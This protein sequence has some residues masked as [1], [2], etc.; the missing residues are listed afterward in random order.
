MVANL[1]LG[2]DTHHRAWSFLEIDGTGSGMIHDVCVRLAARI[3]RLA[4][5]CIAEGDGRI[6]GCMP[7]AMRMDAC[8]HGATMA[9]ILRTLVNH[10]KL[11]CY[12]CMVVVCPFICGSY[13]PCRMPSISAAILLLLLMLMLLMLSVLVMSVMKFRQRNAVLR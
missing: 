7:D 3:R 10:R 5:A 1:D 2:Q 12:C 11:W 13:V 6:P 9:T 4:H 8:M